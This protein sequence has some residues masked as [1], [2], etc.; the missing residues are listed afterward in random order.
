MSVGA[1]L[2]ERTVV[3]YL[4]DRGTMSATRARELTGGVSNVVLLAT[5]GDQR[6]VVKQAL[7]RLRVADIWEAPVGR[8]VTEGRAL[9]FAGRIVPD[10]V[11]ALIDIDPQAHT[12]TLAAAPDSWQ[13]W[14][15][16]L[17]AGDIDPAVG[18]RLGTVLGSLHSARVDADTD[19]LDQQDAFHALRV[20]PYHNAVA[21]RLPIVADQVHAVVDSMAA[22]RR[23][24]VH[25]DYSP[26]NV[27][28]GDNAL[29]VVDFEVAHIGDP[30]FDV[31]FMLSHLILKGIHR[32]TDRDRLR[33]CA[34]EF[35]DAYA[36][37]STQASIV[38]GQHLLGHLSCLLL[39]RAA[40][41]SPVEYLG[42]PEKETV[43]AVASRAL[44]DEVDSVDWLW[45][46]FDGGA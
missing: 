23:C 2:D 26:K 35:V 13:Q 5:N 30:A 22:T 44:T 32:P 40:G 18:A 27:L 42:P 10:F 43:I 6:V 9:R 34:G 12:I 7:Q 37:S 15:S 8:V 14:K 24:F 28:V 16:R 38:Q 31:A 4:A 33:R 1:L 29:W 46:A 3:T 20:D 36:I 39:S 25:G 45:D 21:A 11:P 41:K 17:L 19:W